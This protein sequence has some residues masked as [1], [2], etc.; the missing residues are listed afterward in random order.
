[1]PETQRTCLLRSP[2]RYFPEPGLFLGFAPDLLNQNFRGGAQESPGDLWVVT[3]GLGSDEWFFQMRSDGGCSQGLSG[4]PRPWHNS[5]AL[6][7]A[8]DGPH[9]FD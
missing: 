1:M 2:T 3:V 9:D 5:L 6:G 7:G 4:Y 8:T